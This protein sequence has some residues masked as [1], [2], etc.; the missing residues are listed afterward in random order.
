MCLSSS[1]F[2]DHD[3]DRDE[4]RTVVYV[5]SNKTEDNSILAFHRDE[6][7]ELILVGEFLTGGRGV[8]DPSLALGPVEL[9][10]NIITN[11]EHTLL[12]A[13]NS[14]SD[15]IAVF[16]IRGDGS[17]KHVGG[18]P[19]PS[20]GVNPVS[21]GLSRDTLVVVNKAIDPARPE[22][23]QPNYVTFRVATDGALVAGPI[24]TISAPSGSS[25]T[26]AALSPGKRLAFDAQFLGGMLQSF[27]IEPTGVL[28][29]TDIQA[30]PASEFVGSNQPPFPL[31]LWSHPRHP[32]L[33][34][35]FPT[36]NRL[37]VYTFNSVGRLTFKRGV[38]NAGEAICWLRNNEE[39][40]RLYTTNTADNTVSVYDTTQPLN[41]VEIQTLKLNGVGNPVQLE[42]DPQGNF[43][44]V[45]TQR[46]FDTIPL[47]QGST[48]HAIKVDKVTGRLAQTGLSPVELPVPAATR[49][50]GVVATQVR[51]A[52]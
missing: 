39:G 2:A 38:P 22:L 27:L 24:S 30:L 16:R 10:Q 33:Y 17:L 50:Q 36:I 37:G 1:V 18:S 47:G 41:P 21:V 26:Q 23:N 19:F 5:E 52:Q 49:P 45:V 34:V 43:L 25:P 3:D 12:F 4:P 51:G 6:K 32:I 14:G 44:Y 35:G 46:G 20:G 7:G 40:T 13:A 31:G 42:L 8:F 48:L 29:P 28:T 9:D 15:T 11:A